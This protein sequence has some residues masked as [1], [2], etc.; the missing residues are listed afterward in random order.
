MTL[1]KDEAGAE[2]AAID[3]VVR[4]VKQS[5]IYRVS[6]EIAM[7]WGVM[8]FVQYGV[9]LLAPARF[10]WTWICVDAVGIMLTLLMLQRAGGRVAG[11]ARMLAAFAVFYAFGFIWSGLLSHFG[12]REESVFWHT[13]FLFGYS[14]A[15]IWFGAGFLAIGLGL[16]VLILAV[17]FFAGA[18]FP[19]LIALVA[20]GGYILC[21]YWMRRA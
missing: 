6:G 20:G 1:N 11:P 19:A 15:G 3:D 9:Y 17:Y 10:A 16:T 14:V 13:L 8:Q 2:L 12:A 7:I 4:R 21:G 5:R 18:A